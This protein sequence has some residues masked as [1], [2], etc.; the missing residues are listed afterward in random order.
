MDERTPESWS[1]DAGSPTEHH[2]VQYRSGRT[3]ILRMTT[4][5][6]VWLATQ[7][8]A[9]ES[10]I[11]FA[12]VHAAFMGGL[13]PA[14]FLVWAADKQDPGNWH[15][16]EAV[17]VPDLSMILAL[18]GIIHVRATDHGEEPFPAIHF[19]AGGAWNVQP[20]GG[21]LLPGSIVKG[22]FEFFITELKDIDV[23]YG[24]R[25]DGEDF[26]E[27][28]YEAITQTLPDGPGAGRAH[29]PSGARVR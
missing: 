6:D 23:L 8:F 25:F 11:R 13:Q 19:V 27:N 28:W 4:G 14:R 5:A 22:A 12:K 10:K 18:G 7:Q 17:E 2:A 29:R 24:P 15:H 16:E 3:F 20:F 1:R 9:I 26:P 21:H